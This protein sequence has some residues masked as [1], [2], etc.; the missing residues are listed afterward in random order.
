MPSEEEFEQND[1]VRGVVFNGS[2]PIFF[3]QPR[4]I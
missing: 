1:F 3:F 2:T 4:E